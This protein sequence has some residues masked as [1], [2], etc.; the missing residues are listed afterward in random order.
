[1]AQARII[2]GIRSRRS[3]GDNA[4]RSRAANDR[5]SARAKQGQNLG[6][7]GGS[8]QAGNSPPDAGQKNPES[9]HRQ[10]SIQKPLASR[11]VRS[12]FAWRESDP[13]SF[14]Q[15]SEQS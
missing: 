1:M 15:I 3:A 11:S 8:C 6:L 2:T 14:K 5:R 10:E 4:R 12:P 13:A 9:R 7:N